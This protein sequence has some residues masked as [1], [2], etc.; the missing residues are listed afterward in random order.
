MKGRL[1]EI[2]IPVL[3]LSMYQKYSGFHTDMV[4][5]LLNEIPG[6]CCGY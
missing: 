2:N 4:L 1:K 5:L 6:A 3:W